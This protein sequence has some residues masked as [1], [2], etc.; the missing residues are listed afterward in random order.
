[1]DDVIVEMKEPEFNYKNLFLAAVKSAREVTINIEDY[2]NPPEVWQIS[3]G[4]GEVF[5]F[6]VKDKA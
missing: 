6:S 3:D 1:M 4:S 2:L 5:V